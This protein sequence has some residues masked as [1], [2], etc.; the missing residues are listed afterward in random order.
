MYLNVHCSTVYNSQDM[1]A[2]LWFFCDNLTLT[3]LMGLKVYIPVYQHQNQHCLGNCQTWKFIAPPRPTKSETLGV[4]PV[5]CVLLRLLYDFDFYLK[6]ENYGPMTT[7]QHLF[8][9]FAQ[10]IRK[11]K[12]WGSYDGFEEVEK[13]KTPIILAKN[14]FLQKVG[15][16]RLLIR[17]NC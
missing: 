11:R 6:L 17:K 3:N 4:G 10:F 15:T 7:N 13:Q 5:I 12:D 2:P 8:G 16:V 14:Y 1:E 9:R